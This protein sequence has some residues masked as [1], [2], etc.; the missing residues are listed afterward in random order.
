MNIDLAALLKNQLHLERGVCER[1]VA[2]VTGGGR[3]IGLQTARAFALLGARVVIAEITDEGK[4]A[5][6]QILAEGGQALFVRTNVA[7]P[8]SVAELRQ[9]VAQELGHVDYLIN[10][11]IRCP[12]ISAIEMPVETWDSVLA[13]NLRGTFLMCK[14]FLPAMLERKSG[15]VVNMISTE[16]M[17]GLSAY[18]ASKQA[19]LG[20]SQ[21]LSQEIPD[22]GVQVIPFGPGMV[23]TPGIR[24]VSNSLA[25]RLGMTADQFMHLSLH[26]AYEGLMPS[27]HAGAATAFLCVRLAEEYHGMPVNGYEVLERAGVFTPVNAAAPT[28]PPPPP[29]RA[30]AGTTETL[31]AF[32]QMLDDTRTEFGKLPIFVRPLAR[33]GFKSKAGASLEDWQRL[34]QELQI[35]LDQI[36]DFSER[37]GFPARLDQLAA[38]YRG[39][40]A[41]TAR[42]TRDAAILR[43]IETLCSRRLALIDQLKSLFDA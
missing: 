2:V 8:V 15:V 24:E 23:E 22:A 31:A 30:H 40:P 13:V 36:S 33:Q 7:D 9:E 4:Q 39:V 1:Q 25:P 5:E 28:V 38:Y 41:E 21:S 43:E 17:P 6:A 19:I 12:V 37:K 29:A 32:I 3:G 27:E 14:A 26:P 10:N 16:A 42:F 34:A 35:S 11:A 18:I 20:F